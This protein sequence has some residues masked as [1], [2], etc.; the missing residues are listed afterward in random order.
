MSLLDQ[1]PH[2]V[3]I[4]RRT[5]QQDELGGDV[6]IW[7]DVATDVEAWVQVASASD[8]KEFEK[9]GMQI[10]HA[11]YFNEDPEI[12]ETNQ[13][14]YNGKTFQ[15]GAV[16]EDSVGFDIVWKAMVTQY[17]TRDP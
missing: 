3:T 2:T 1:F 4:Q 5:N 12:N 8:I 7:V 15:F 9:Q 17:T 13:I 14:I 11:V 16:Q 10:T 6:E